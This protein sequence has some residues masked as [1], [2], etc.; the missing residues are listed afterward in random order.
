MVGL[1]VS[2]VGLPSHKDFQVAEVAVGD[3]ILSSSSLSVMPPSARSA[4][5]DTLPPFC[6][7]RPTPRTSYMHS[8][9]PPPPVLLDPAVHSVCIA[10]PSASAMIPA[11]IV[12]CE[13]VA[14]ACVLRWCSLLPLEGNSAWGIYGAHHQGAH[15]WAHSSGPVALSLSVSLKFTVFFF[16]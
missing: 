13:H 10:K 1:P 5:L 14:I 9:L 12:C 7:S 6:P 11:L 3:L 4:I 8:F 15:C 16:F 2:I